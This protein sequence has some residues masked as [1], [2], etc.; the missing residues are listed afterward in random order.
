MFPIPGCLRAGIDRPLNSIYRKC[1]RL[2]PKPTTSKGKFSADEIETLKSLYSEHGPNWI[3]IGT[4]MNRNPDSVRDKHRCLK[5]NGE[6]EGFWSEAEMEKLKE[7]VE[8]TY[9]NQQKV[10]IVKMNWKKISELVGSRY[11]FRSL[12][13]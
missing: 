8:E 6:N 12:S 3:K 9:G 7:A 5:C 2:Y 11:L 1:L 10:P 13:R 4:L